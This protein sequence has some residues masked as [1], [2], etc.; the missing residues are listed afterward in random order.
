MLISFWGVRVLAVLACMK[1]LLLNRFFDVFIMGFVGLNMLASRCPS[2]HFVAIHLM[3]DYAGL[4]N[5]C[6]FTMVS[7]KCLA[8]GVHHWLP[9]AM[10][11]P[12]VVSALIHAATLV[13]LGVV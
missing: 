6:M 8:I 12:T 5:V 10:E 4:I 1:G 11:G 3:A 2:V 13:I 7:V 9:D